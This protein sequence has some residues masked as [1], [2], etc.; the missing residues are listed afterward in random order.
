MTLPKK[1]V[2]VTGG[3]HRI[4]KAVAKRFLDDGHA[5][6]MAEYDQE[7]GAETLEEFR[8]LGEVYFSTRMWL[9]KTRSGL[10][11]NQL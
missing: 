10:L 5:V 1:T 2:I 4:G 6:V 8:P 7:A 9:K 11:S 3:A